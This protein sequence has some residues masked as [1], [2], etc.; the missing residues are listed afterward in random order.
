MKNW[1]T[2][3]A[4]LI[5]ALMALTGCPAPTG[6]DESPDSGMVITEKNVVLKEE[7][8]VQPAV[9]QVQ[10]FDSDTGRITVSEDV[11]VETGQ[12]FHSGVTDEFP[13]GALKKVVGVE[14]GAD[15]EK[16]LITEDAAL[17]D[18]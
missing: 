4:L 11:A 9:A 15:G 1:R 2:I 3:G 6:G 18:M 16:V 5:I 14:T 17:T 13:N 8:L 7:A 10:S 12:V